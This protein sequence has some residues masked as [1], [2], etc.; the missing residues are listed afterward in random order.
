MGSRTPRV[1]IDEE[2]YN[3]TM[4]L[5][6]IPDSAYAACRAYEAEFKL[7]D[8]LVWPCFLC[9]KPISDSGG[10]GFRRKRLFHDECAVLIRLRQL[11]KENGQ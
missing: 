1:Y 2:D 4:R 8:G 7:V 6:T 11:G 10:I 5:D 9:H 3:L